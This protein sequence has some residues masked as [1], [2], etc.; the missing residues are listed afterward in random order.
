[1]VF[2]PTRSIHSIGWRN[3][4]PKNGGLMDGLMIGWTLRLYLLFLLLY[5]QCCNALIM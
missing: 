5:H 3:S 1:M 2:D 4:I